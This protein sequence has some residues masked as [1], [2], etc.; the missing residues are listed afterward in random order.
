[1]FEQFLDRFG[2]DKETMK[3]PIW[4]NSVLMATP[5]YSTISSK[6]AG[7]MIGDGLLYFFT[8]ADGPNAQQFLVDAFPEFSGNAV[9]FARDW[10]GRVFAVNRMGIPE[11]TARLFLVEPGAAEVFEID[12]NFENF[13]NVALVNEPDTYLESDLWEVWRSSGGGAPNIDQCV[14]FKT[15]L[16]LG[17]SGEIGNLELSD[18]QIYWHICGRM[19]IATRDLPPGTKI[20][21]ADLQ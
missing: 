2:R 6:I 4:R 5:G 12:E 8:Q 20:G 13:L 14:G 16:F 9:P 18:L 17:G 21:R 3:A 7:Q 11:G 15:P 1:M 19:R 10:L